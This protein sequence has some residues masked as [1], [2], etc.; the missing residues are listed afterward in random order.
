MEIKYGTCGNQGDNYQTT[1]ASSGQP[2]QAKFSLDVNCTISADSI[3][4]GVSFSS[5]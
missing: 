2:S 5:S 4:N 3:P 1:F